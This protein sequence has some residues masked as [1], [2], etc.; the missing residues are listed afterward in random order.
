MP[1]PPAIRYQASAVKAHT[2]RRGVS[3]SRLLTPPV[4]IQIYYHASLA[5][6]VAAWEAYIEN[7]VRD[8]F[9]VTADPLNTKFHAV[10]TIA[11][12]AAEKSLKRFNTP[13]SENSRCILVQTTGYD[14]LNDWVWIQRGMNALT[15]RQRLDEILQA[16][17]SFAHCFPIP[18][19]S[20]NQTST[21]TSQAHSKIN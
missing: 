17:H 6:F 9:S 12:E 3:N 13:N 15:T 20:W 19:Y 16:R 7:L 18:R 5:A 2:L 21:G 11:S 14:P 10:H 8:F 1:S 4:D